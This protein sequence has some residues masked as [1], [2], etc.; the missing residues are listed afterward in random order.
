[1]SADLLL[2]T[3]RD[4]FGIRRASYET[5][6]IMKHDERRA[7]PLIGRHDFTP[8]DVCADCETSSWRVGSRLAHL[9]LSAAVWILISRHV[10]V[11]REIDITD[12]QN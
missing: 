3:R 6:R 2:R 11:R 12:E 10:D 8:V 5:G 7:T 9:S 4:A 1:M